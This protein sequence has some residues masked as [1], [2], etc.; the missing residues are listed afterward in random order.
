MVAQCPL[1]HWDISVLSG[2]VDKAFYYILPDWSRLVV[3]SVCQP[4]RRVKLKVTETKEKENKTTDD[5]NSHIQGLLLQ[6]LYFLWFF[7]FLTFFF[8][9]QIEFYDVTPKYYWFRREIKKI[10]WRYI[11]LVSREF[12][13]KFLG[14]D[15]RPFADVTFWVSLRRICCGTSKML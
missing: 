13:R 11:G 12:E 8:D 2:Y 9:K 3:G 4:S 5:F 7:C 10:G 6:F 15:R 14:F 1:S